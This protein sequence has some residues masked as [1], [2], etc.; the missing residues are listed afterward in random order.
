MVQCS[1]K[2]AATE[3]QIQDDVDQTTIAIR[4]VLKTSLPTIHIIKIHMSLDWTDTHV[5]D[6][7]TA[8]MAK[9]FNDGIPHNFQFLFSLGTFF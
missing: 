2:D 7:S 3:S 6:N 9:T 4:Q 8:I 1:V 5:L